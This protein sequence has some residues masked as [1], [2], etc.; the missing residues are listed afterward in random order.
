MDQSNY[1]HGTNLKF[2]IGQIILPAEKAGVESN[3]DTFIDI[4]GRGRIPLLEGLSEHAFATDDD[5]EAMKA[6]E[7]AVGR[8]NVG[9]AR[10]YRVSPVDINDIEGDPNSMSAIRSRSGFKVEEE[11]ST[12][13]VSAFRF[14]V[15]GKAYFLHHSTASDIKVGE[16]IKT[17]GA[18]KQTTA[19]DALIGRSYGWDAM[20]PSSIKNAMYNQAGGQYIYI[21]SA[22]AQNVFPDI[23][24]PF[25]NARAIKGEQT[26]LDM[27][28]IG[29]D[30]T[31][32]SV[33]KRIFAKLQS[34]N[35]PIRTKEEADLANLEMLIS[36]RGR[37]ATDEH[38]AATFEGQLNDIA[39][40][41]NEGNPAYS[42]TSY[43]FPDRGRAYR[44]GGIE[45]LK[46]QIL[47]EETMEA[48]TDRRGAPGHVKKMNELFS[49][50]GKKSG[51][52][53]GT[54]SKRTLSNILESGD[55]AIK[56]MRGIL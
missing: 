12:N 29:S 31:E 47:K 32:D 36:D 8:K 24:V 50:V 27:V 13:N 52:E 1:F 23:N 19:G 38:I 11:I 40:V 22:D 45:G 49:A 43:L 4:P 51:K 37:Q 42:E 18:F 10:I 39:R 16:S 33:Q 20:N 56:V 35:I 54:M 28:K 44:S 55:T 30:E 48:F 7:R 34:L 14:D 21:T 46:A 3:Y 9:E 25:S 53:L 26:V 6:A 41:I 5:I 17:T 2:N 15:D